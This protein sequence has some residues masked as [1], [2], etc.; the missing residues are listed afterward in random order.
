MNWML[1]ILSIS[2]RFLSF[3]ELPTKETKQSNDIEVVNKVCYLLPGVCGPNKHDDSLCMYYGIFFSRKN[4]YIPIKKW[5][6]GT[7]D[8]NLNSNLPWGVR[9]L[10]QRAFTKTSREIKEWIFYMLHTW[11][12]I[13][14]KC[15]FF[16]WRI[17][18]KS[19]K[20]SFLI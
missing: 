4:Y 5:K 1:E 17:S 11:T 3:Y 2:I 9:L 19:I 16:L 12:H 13:V 20:M 10:E 15:Y 7:H 8:S 14:K 6:R 18:W